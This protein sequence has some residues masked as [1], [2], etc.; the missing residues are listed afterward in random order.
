MN[1]ISVIIVMLVI[2]S[3]LPAKYDKSSIL[4]NGLAHSRIVKEQPEMGISE[5][6]RQTQLSDPE[7]TLWRAKFRESKQEILE[8]Y[9]EFKVMSD[10][11]N[12][13]VKLALKAYFHKNLDSF[14]Y[15]VPSNFEG[16]T[17]S[18]S[19]VSLMEDFWAFIDENP[20]SVELLK[21][22]YRLNEA[23]EIQTCLEILDADYRHG[24]DN[25]DRFNEFV[26]ML[27]ERIATIQPNDGPFLLPGGML[28]KASRGGGHAFH[29]VISA[30]LNEAGERRLQFE[31]INRG[32]GISQH[33]HDR[34]LEGQII[35]Q[36]FVI[37]DIDPSAIEKGNFLASMM[38]LKV[39][40]PRTEPWIPFVSE[41]LEAYRWKGNQPIFEVYALARSFL[42]E[43]GGGHEA[44]MEDERFWHHEQKLGTC[45]MRALTGFMRENM[46]SKNMHAF[47]YFMSLRSEEKI[48]RILSDPSKREEARL[49]IEK[50]PNGE[51]LLSQ[52]DDQRFFKLFFEAADHVKTKRELKHSI[53]T[54]G[55]AGI[56]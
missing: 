13:N 33:L 38:D 44:R 27:K 12:G 23:Y 53:E 35:Y 56:L 32:W 6:S 43:Q 49:V 54:R 2:L 20:D 34:D 30:Y 52:I 47:R 18:G 11:L 48:K 4:R 5:K 8:K 25:L 45:T 22:G 29:Y 10:E 9:P 31:I 3:F 19:L 16:M 14:K 37:T 41:Q 21:V 7:L 40:S 1:N 42:V 36:S 17:I 26:A 15:Q 51:Q 50:S 39:L 55:R 24:V 46:S 28:R